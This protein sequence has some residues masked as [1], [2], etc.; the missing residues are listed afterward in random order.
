VPS[1]VLWSRPGHDLGWLD[2][3]AR[4]GKRLLGH[5]PEPGL[6]AIG[7]GS[8]APPPSRGGVAGRL[9]ARLMV[10][11]FVVRGRRAAAA[12]EGVVIHDRHAV[13]AAV[14][15]AF[16]YQ[17][18]RPWVLPLTRLATLRPDVHVYLDI[19]AATASRRKPDDTMRLAA[20][21]E[22]V[23]RYGRLVPLVPGLTRVDATQPTPVITGRLWTMLLD[24]CT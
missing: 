15:L 4:W 23:E 7:A 24:A 13:D 1:T 18:D 9:W 2:S 3:V 6:R 10:L 20:I 12:A 22:Q 14:T 5:Q 16:A 17:L 8:E 19:D 11:D 21:T